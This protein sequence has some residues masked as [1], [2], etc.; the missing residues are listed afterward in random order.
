[1]FS[2]EFMKFLIGY[3]KSEPKKEKEIRLKMK[4]TVPSAVLVTN[5]EK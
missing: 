4:K 1:M 5:K 3:Q 2:P